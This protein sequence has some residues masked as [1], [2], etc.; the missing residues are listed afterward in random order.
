MLA[1]VRTVIGLSLGLSGLACATKQVTAKRAEKWQPEVG[2]SWQ[3]VLHGAIDLDDPATLEP[4]VDIYDLDLYENDAEVFSQLHSMG[5]KVICYFSGGSYEDWRPDAIDFDS[6]DL[7][8]PLDEW[9]GENWI[10][11]GTDNVR[12]IMTKRVELAAEKGCDAIDPDNVDG[13][14][15]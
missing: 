8:A 4:D 2:A 10:D 1:P 3:I 14:V 12:K 15:S 9:E 5:K 13:Y 6:G 11:L 7:G